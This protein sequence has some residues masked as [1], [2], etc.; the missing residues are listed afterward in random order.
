MSAVPGNI[1]V[2]TIDGPGGSGKGTIAM[3]LAQDLGWHLL[4]SGALYR[5][6]AGGTVTT[7]LEIAGVFVTGAAM[8]LGGAAT[9]IQRTI[10][11]L[12]RSCRRCRRVC[13]R[14]MII[15]QRM[16][17]LAVSPCG[18]GITVFDCA[19]RIICRHDSIRVRGFSLRL[20]SMEVGRRGRAGHVFIDVGTQEALV[21]LF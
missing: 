10:V 9:V 7:A 1:P 3:R 5:I 17:H 4:D 15:R 18:R 16:T 2:V 20:V 8:N 11:A 13:R 6:V 12:R 21:V 19:V 14:P